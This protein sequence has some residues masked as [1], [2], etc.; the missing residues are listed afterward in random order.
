MI[1]R[2][3]DQNRETIQWSIQISSTKV[4]EARCT[5]SGDPHY[6]TFDGR[7]YD[8]NGQCSYTLVKHNNFTVEVE[9]VAC[10]G[11]IPTRGVCPECQKMKSTCTK[12]I[13]VR[14][15]L[16]I[17][18]AYFLSEFEGCKKYCNGQHHNTLF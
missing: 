15:A 13:A 1:Q 16:I 2:L 9:N 8:F 17:F 4:C 14:S 11:A 10:G 18:L 6:T 3:H 5:V 12:S 7:H